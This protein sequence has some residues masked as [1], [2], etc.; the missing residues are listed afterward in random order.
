MWTWVQV[1]QTYFE[2]LS[3]NIENQISSQHYL[4]YTNVG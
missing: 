3:F 4:I 1:I 2:P